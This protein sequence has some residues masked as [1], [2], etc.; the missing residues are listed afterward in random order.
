MMNLL[1]DN[2]T[3][4]IRSLTSANI[5]HF[6]AGFSETVLTAY[7]RVCTLCFLSSLKKIVHKSSLSFPFPLSTSVSICVF[8]L[9]K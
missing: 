8:F 1:Y 6:S 4:Q 2:V 7:M 9:Y 3:S 5:V